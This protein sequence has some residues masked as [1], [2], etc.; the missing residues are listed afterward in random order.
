MG[1]GQATHDPGDVN[2]TDDFLLRLKN[3]GIDFIGT[4]ISQ[5]SSHAIFYVLI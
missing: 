1:E 5:I 3:G 2:I 4:P